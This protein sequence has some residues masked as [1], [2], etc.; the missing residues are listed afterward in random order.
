L[1]EETTSVLWESPAEL[2]TYSIRKE[3]ECVLINIKSNYTRSVALA[4]EETAPQLVKLF[5][6]VGVTLE[7]RLHP[8][9]DSASCICCKRAVICT[10]FTVLWYRCCRRTV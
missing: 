1:K 4:C 2:L 6:G 3:G 10:Q 8:S 7:V 5:I 9:R